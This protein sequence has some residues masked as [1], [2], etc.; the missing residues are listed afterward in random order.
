MLKIIL[1][2]A[3]LTFSAM[4]DDEDDEDEEDKE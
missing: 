3:L 4:A 2:V 1:T